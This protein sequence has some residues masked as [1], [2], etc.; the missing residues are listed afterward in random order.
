[1]VRNRDTIVCIVA[2]AIQVLVT[3]AAVVRVTDVRGSVSVLV[4]RPRARPGTARRT[5]HHRVDVGF[6]DPTIPAHLDLVGAG[7]EIEAER[8]TLEIRPPTLPQNTGIEVMGRREGTLLRPRVDGVGE[9]HGLLENPEN[10]TG[11]DA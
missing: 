9:I 3:G 11:F 4:S 1:M 10:V 6:A 8:R 7:L 2:S 5:E